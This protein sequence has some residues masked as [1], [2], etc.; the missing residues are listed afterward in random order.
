MQ[1]SN[2]FWHGNPVPSEQLKSRNKE[3]RRIVGRLAKGEST[4]ITGSFR[5]F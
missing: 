4:I 2:P 1:H 3:I 5:E